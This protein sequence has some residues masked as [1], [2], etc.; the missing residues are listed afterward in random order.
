ML[1]EYLQNVAFVGICIVSL[2]YFVLVQF[3]DQDRLHYS[4]QCVWLSDPW[5]FVD[6]ILTKDGKITKHILITVYPEASYAQFNNIY[7]LIKIYRVD[8]VFR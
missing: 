2:L 5:R 8:N 4:N 1:N 7:S 6:S 3:P